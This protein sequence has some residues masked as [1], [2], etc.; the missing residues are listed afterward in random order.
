[1]MAKRNQPSAGVS[2]LRYSWLSQL[3]MGHARACFSSIVRLSR[4]P[5]ATLLTMIVVGISL[6]LP[7]GLFVLVQNAQMLS[8]QWN[9]GQQLS[10][11][12]RMDVSQ[13]EVDE[14]LVK[15][16]LDPQISSFQ[17]ITPDEALSEFQEAAGMKT[18]LES[19]PSNPLPGVVIVTPKENHSTPSMR[20]LVSRLKHDPQVDLVQ[21]DYRWIERLLTII[22]LLKK[23]VWA[24]AMLLGVGV[25]MVIGNTIRLATENHRNELEIIRLM[26]ATNAF[27]RRPLLYTG[28]IFGVLGGIIAWLCVDFMILWLQSTVTHLANLYSSHFHL[29]ELGLFMALSMIM[30]GGGLGFLASYVVISREL[31]TMA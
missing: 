13:S 15:L 10:L 17:Y 27:I 16:Q 26:G 6:A 7:L 23:F 2:S 9:K 8:Q 31:R 1:M 24:F 3:F 28:T 12:L 19:L 18:L 14:F 30:M 4:T 22:L 21:F 20:R 25:I 29:D 11:F 5:F